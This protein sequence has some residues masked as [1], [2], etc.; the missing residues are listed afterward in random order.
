[1]GI[2]ILVATWLFFSVAF[3]IG[4]KSYRTRKIEYDGTI[5][6]SPSEDGTTVTLNLDLD[7]VVDKNTIK[8]KVVAPPETA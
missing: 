8:L 7:D 5:T 6:V 3:Y 2:E 1:M 4:N